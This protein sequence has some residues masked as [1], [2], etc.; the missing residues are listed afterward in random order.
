MSYEALS[1]IVA[2]AAGELAFRQMLLRDPAEALCGYSLSAAE[3]ASL[4]GLTA[5][6]LDALKA[7]LDE[8]TSRSFVFG[9]HREPEPAHGEGL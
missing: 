8:R 6:T 1:H 3:I 4:S 9:N 2:R 7:D 5:E